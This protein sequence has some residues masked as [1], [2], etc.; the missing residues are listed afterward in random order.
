MDQFNLARDSVE[1]DRR[2]GPQINATDP[3]LS[4]FKARGGKLIMYH[5]WSDPALPPRTTIDYYE[6]IRAT[7]GGAQTDDFVR[8]YMVPG[9]QHCFAGPGTHSFGQL[10]PGG[11]ADPKRNISAALEAWV[12]KG[13]AP[14]AIIAGKYK[15]EL[16]SVFAPEK[17]K[18]LRT[19][20]ICPYP[21]VAKWSGKGSTD[22]AENFSCEINRD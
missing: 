17:S 9:L 18:L 3:D 6:R 14:Q 13:E 15:E 7:M 21:Q 8:L 19:R 1:F 11:T 22:R 20:P 10:V 2:I 4:R 16:K 12:E 5:G